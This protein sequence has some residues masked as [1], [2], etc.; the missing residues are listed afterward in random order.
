MAKNEFTLADLLKIVGDVEKPAS[1]KVVLDNS[2]GSLSMKGV[3]IS[4]NLE[5]SILTI[6]SGDA[7]L[8][9]N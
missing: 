5:D 1:V 8:K 9:S 4:A 2:T 6:S 3:A 7:I